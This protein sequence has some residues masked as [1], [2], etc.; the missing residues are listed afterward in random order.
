MF[1]R[2][3]RWMLSH[4]ERFTIKNE[5]GE[6][7]MNRYYLLKWPLRIRLHEILRSDE[8]RDMHDHP[9]D[10]V[11]VMLKG[12]YVETTPDTPAKAYGAGSIRRL[13]AENVHS[14]KLFKQCH[15]CNRS[16]EEQGKLITAWTLIFAGKN[17]REWGFHTPDGWVHWKKY[18]DYKHG[19]DGLQTRLAEKEMD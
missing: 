12:G 15:C 2:L 9:Y 11:S 3:F 14:I 13:K 6:P 5:N 19:K 8:D 10:F 18:M 17:R 7:Y 4:C 1:S 16:A